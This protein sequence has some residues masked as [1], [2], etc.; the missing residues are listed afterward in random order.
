[1]ITTIIFDMDGVLVDTMKLHYTAWKKLLEEKGFKG[2]NKKIYL[3]F[4]GMKTV[5][6]LQMFKKKH[7]LKINP[8]QDAKRKEELVNFSKMALFS[9]VKPTLKEL[10]K[11]G[12][13]IGIAT[14]ASHH[15]MKRN[16]SLFGISAYFD[17]F[18]T[19]NDVVHSKPN[20]QIYLLSAKKLNSSPKECVVIED[21]VNGVIAAKKAGMKCMGI[22]N[23]FPK[24]TLKE[25]GADYVVENVTEL[26]T[27]LEK[28][29]KI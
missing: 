1:M 14:S 15:I 13:K 7:N 10:R 3:S 16:L 21:A 4:A 18:T 27:L 26:L 9:G 12:F 28:I 11:S 19:A 17:S 5:E 24:Q 8:E 29:N 22:T 2:F 6:I 25:A 23:T 20:P